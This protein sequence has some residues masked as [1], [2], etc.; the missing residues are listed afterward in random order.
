MRNELSTPQNTKSDRVLVIGGS[1]LEQ[2]L[3]LEQMSSWGLD[4]CATSSFSE[5]YQVIEIAIELGSPVG[6]VLFD[7]GI[8]CEK[9][10]NFIDRVREHSTS[11]VLP[12]LA[13][14]PNSFIKNELSPC[15][16]E[17]AMTLVKP[18]APSLL[19]KTVIELLKF[20]PDSCGCENQWNSADYPE[21]KLD[22]LIAE[23]NEVNQIVFT[24]ILLDL[25][26][27]FKIANNGEEAVTLWKEHRPAIVLMDVSMPVMNGHEATREIRQLEQDTTYRTPICAITAHALRGDKEDCIAAGMDD[28]LSKPVSPDMLMD[29]VKSMLPLCH[30]LSTR[31]SVSRAA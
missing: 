16:S 2:E 25:G 24:Q 15:A 18:C 9:F 14:G 12:F 20:E 13:V 26:I 10:K 31:A 3:Y 1:T 29:K 22:V 7:Q 30:P 23:D 4:A 19:E 17:M 8:C 6:L 5:A 27:D 21:F 28:Y 11:E